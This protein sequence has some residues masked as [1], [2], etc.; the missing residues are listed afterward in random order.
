MFKSFHIPGAIM[1]EDRYL[2]KRNEIS[3]RNCSPRGNKHHEICL[4]HYTAELLGNGW[5]TAGWNRRWYQEMLMN[6]ITGLRLQNAQKRQANIRRIASELSRSA[7]WHD[8]I[9]CQ[10]IENRFTTSTNQELQPM[11]WAR[12]DP[13]K[14]FYLEWLLKWTGSRKRLIGNQCKEEYSERDW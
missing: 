11:D 3:K 9:S 14:G 13:A 1:A 8:A 10:E 6:G 7:W 5:Q 4:Y 2:I 12:H